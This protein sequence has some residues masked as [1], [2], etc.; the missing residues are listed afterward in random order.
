MRPRHVLTVVVVVAALV[1]AGC[2]DAPTGPSRPFDLQAHRGGVALT[3]EGTLPAFARGLDAGV[4]T[5]EMDVQVTADGRDVITHDRRTSTRTCRDTAPAFPG[6][7]AFPYVGKLVRELTFAQVRTLD[8]GSVRQPRWPA[9]RLAPGAPMPTLEEVAHLVHDRHAPVRFDVETK[10]EAA[11]PTETAPREAFVTRVVD[12]VHRL[13]IADRTTVES[14]DWGSLREVHA[15]DP[16]LATEALVEPGFLDVGRPG[17]SPWLGG[18]DADDVG[19]DPVR[20]ALAL[21]IGVSVLAPVHGDPQDGGVTTP[22]Y[23][24][25]TTPAMVAEAHTAGMRVVAWTVDDAPTVRALLDAGVDGLIT[26]DPPVVRGVLA[27][28]GIPLPPTVP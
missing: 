27:E 1:T 9:Q 24:P 26:D 28:R 20:A 6:D 16:G 21:G 12:E 13:G 10:V 11:A 18:V 3:A 8:C 19:G 7:P 23:R 22:G 2:A 5:L 4:S 25:F 17:A 15:R 14:F